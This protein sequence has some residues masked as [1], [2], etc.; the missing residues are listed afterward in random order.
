[1]HRLRDVDVILAMI[2][3]YGV[4]AVFDERYAPVVIPRLAAMERAVRSRGLHMVSGTINAPMFGGQSWLAH[5]TLLTGLWIDSH[6]RYEL[7]LGTEPDTLVE[8]F[9]RTG[10][11]TVAVMPA[12]TMPW[13]EGRWFGFDAIHE[14]RDI[15]YQGPPFHWV[16]MPDQYTWSFFHHEVRA[17]KARPLFAKLALVS[18]HAPWV[19]ILPVID[20]W[21]RV[22]DGSIFRKWEGFGEAPESL[23]RDH[24]R[25]REHYA[26]SVA[27]AI[28]VA[29]GYAERFVDGRTLLILMGDHQ[30]ARMITG[31]DASRAAPVHVISGDPALLEPFRERG[32][33]DGPL[34]PEEL[35]DR[36][37]DHFRAWMLEG[38]GT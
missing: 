21:S 15:P 34:P 17:R 24:D 18:S 23:W 6:L 10:H 7:L 20:D 33:V 19:P 1:L 11:D 3:S 16:T 9:R 27:Y 37:M 13:P 35:T 12:I 31:P 29:S 25:V 4:S 26:L 38:F 8:D 22:G 28:E 36:N 14:A 32:F 30:P 5:A 2:E